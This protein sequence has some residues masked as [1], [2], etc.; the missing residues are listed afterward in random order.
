MREDLRNAVI[1][2][3]KCTVRPCDISSIFNGVSKQPV[4]E[5]VSPSSTGLRIHVSGTVAS[6]E[7]AGCTD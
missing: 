4:Q 6:T 2:S 3:Y 5:L 7:L 1:A